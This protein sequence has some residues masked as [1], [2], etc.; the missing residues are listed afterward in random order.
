MPFGRSRRVANRS[1]RLAAFGVALPLVLAACW[2]R[3]YRFEATASYRAPRSALVLEGVASGFVPAGRDTSRDY[4]GRFR[5]RAEGG[6]AAGIDLVLSSRTPDECRVG[7]GGGGWLPWRSSSAGR[8]LGKALERAGIA[9]AAPAE[10][11]ELARAMDGLVA[12]PKGAL[13]EGQTEVLE[14][15]EVRLDYPIR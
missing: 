1:G 11:D 14:V 2:P 3:D 6:D 9:V 12:G 13:L 10:L 7:G 15:V 4:E 8:S 5:L